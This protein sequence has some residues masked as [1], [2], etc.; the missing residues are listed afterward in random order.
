M[1]MKEFGPEASVTGPPLRSANANVNVRS[2][3]QIFSDAPISDVGQ[4]RSL[5]NIDT[6]SNYML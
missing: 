6:P 1:K 3:H 5:L 4:G 2:K